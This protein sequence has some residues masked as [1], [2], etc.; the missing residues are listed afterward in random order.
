MAL[1]FCLLSTLILAAC[2]GIDDPSLQSTLDIRNPEPLPARAIVEHNDQRNLLW[3]DLHVHTSLSYDAYSMGVRV[4]PDDAYRYFKGGTISHG[5]GYAVRAKR[6]ID[7]AAVTDHAEYLGAPRHLAGDKA[8]DN[9]LPEILATGSPLRITWHWLYTMLTAK[10]ENPVARY[11]DIDGLGDVAVAA[12]QTTI[13]AAEAHND[14]GRFTAF[15]A[16]EYTSM[17]GGQ[18]LHRNVI[19]KGSNVIDIPFSS[20]ESDNPEDLWTVLERERAKGNDNLAIPHNGNA[21]NGLMFDRRTYK[22]RELDAAYAARRMANEPLSEIFQVKGSSETHPELSPNDPFASHELFTTIFNPAGD[23]G[24]VPGSYVRN[25]LRDGLEYNSKQGFNPYQFGF[26][27]SS[28]S[29]NG[30]MADEEDNFHGKQPL[31]DGSAGQR[32]GKVFLLPDSVRRTGQWG[33]QGLAAVWA[34]ENT[35][36]SIFNALR[37]K[38]TYATTGPRITLRFFGGWGFSENILEQA[39]WTE[40]AYSI[41]VPMGASIS[42]SDQQGPPSFVVLA[43]KDPIGANLDR[44][45]IIKGWTDAV[46]N[47]HERIYDIAGAGNRKVDPATGLLPAIG[48]TVN[49]DEASY[50]N[51]IGTA[52]LATVWQDPDF[53]ADQH[54]FYYTRVIEIPTPRYSTY[55][56]RALGVDAPA[57]TTIQERAVSSAIW[58]Q[59]GE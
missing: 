31:M 19:F 30:T 53:S 24:K 45:Q 9:A 15:V 11:G 3:G 29:H 40:E 23:T 7:F 17:P 39:D 47:S 26:I 37:R 57:P 55:D 4:M 25:A 14:P 13:E 54:A 21:S 51:D 49:V 56:A 42:D 5:A 52:Q 36:D 50:S 38:E 32:L 59:P 6:P 27:G 48:N 18:N 35:R 41:G 33:S 16:Y 44:L 20:V 8:E 2:G 12:W 43:A 1:P 22:G 46:G 10:N 34:H 28:D 58:Y